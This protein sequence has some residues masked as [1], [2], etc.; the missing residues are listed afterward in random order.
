MGGKANKYLGVLLEVVEVQDVVGHEVVVADP[1][2][3]PVGRPGLALAHAVDHAGVDGHGARL[4]VVLGQELGVLLGAVQHH[5][6][7]VQ[8]VQL[9]AL[10]LVGHRVVG[11]LEI[12]S[13][14]EEKSSEGPIRNRGSV[15]T[16]NVLLLKKKGSVV[17]EKFF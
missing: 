15:C 3:H 14:G 5:V 8:P 16:A 7:E 10:G 9:T 11:L 6:D 2:G 4:H 13:A 12:V 17:I 1:A